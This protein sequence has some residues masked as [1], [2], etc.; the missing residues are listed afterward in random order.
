[1]PGDYGKVEQ[2]GRITMLGRGSVS[3]NSGGEKIFPEEVEAA[4]KAHAGIFDCV[5]CGVPDEKWG[6]RVTAVAQSRSL[7]APSLEAIQIHCRTKLAGYKIPRRIHY[8]DSIPR[9][10]AGKPDYQWAINVAQNKLT[11]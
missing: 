4:I 9:S 7:P 11:K 1:M 10:P 6:S 2:D 5:V 3:I 8:V